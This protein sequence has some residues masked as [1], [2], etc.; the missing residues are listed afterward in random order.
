MAESES[1]GR[2]GRPTALTAELTGLIC[3][4]IREGNYRDVAAVWAGISVRTLRDWCTRAS[5]E[6]GGIHEEFLR[7]VLEAEQAAEMAMVAVVVESAKVDTQNA[8]WYLERKF[9]QRWASNRAEMRLL[10]RRLDQLEKDAA[11]QNSSGDSKR[12]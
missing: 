9:P 10:K 5:R 4:S 8:R 7:A 11:C 6:P 3:Q 1:K 2:G 12:G